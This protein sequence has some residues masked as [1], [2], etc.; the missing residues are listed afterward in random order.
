M[1]ELEE[2]LRR[3]ENDTSARK[4]DP[5]CDFNGGDCNLSSSFPCIFMLGRAYGKWGSVRVVASAF[6]VGDSFDAM[7]A[8][9]MPLTI[10]L[11][12][13]K[14]SVFFSASCIVQTLIIQPMLCND[15]CA[16]ARTFG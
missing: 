4:Q 3:C 13:P 9:T 15:S 11:L 16:H 10:Q 8:C 14:C 12:F 7:N 2:A 6:G 5:L 1:E